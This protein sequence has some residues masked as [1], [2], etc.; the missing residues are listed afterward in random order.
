MVGEESTSNGYGAGLVPKSEVTNGFVLEVGDGNGSGSLGPWTSEGLRTY[1]RRKLAKVNS[2][3]KSVEDGRSSAEA[4]VRDVGGRNVKDNSYE[5]V[6]LSKNRCNV[7][8]ND[9]DPCLGRHMRDAVLEQM[10][11]SLRESE[12]GI[13][14]C[15]QNAIVCPPEAN[16]ATKVKDT[17]H[18]HEDKNRWFS[19]MK[20]MPDGSLNAAGGHAGVT[21]NGTLDE[22]NCRS[23]TER[24]ERALFSVIESEQFSSLCKLLVENFQGIKVDSFFDFRLINSRIKEGAYEDS[25]MLFSSDIQQVWK[26]VQKI[27]S[28][29]LSL[30]K[31]VSDITKTSC[32]EWVQSRI[33]TSMQVGGSAHST[34]EDGKHEFCGRETDA[35]LEQ[36]GACGVN[37]ACACRRCGGKADGKD[38]LVCDSCEE[39]YH[40]SCIEPA[41]KEIPAR[42]WYCADC[43]ASGIGS[44]H[45][46]CVV[47]ERLNAPK[48]RSNAVTDIVAT[49]ELEE[50]SDYIMEDGLQVLGGSRILCICK[51]CRGEIENGEKFRLCGHPYCQFKCLHVRCLTSKQLK[52]YGPLWYCPSCLCRVCL[53]DRDDD[54]IV[55]CD[56]CD[57]AYHIY[58]MEPPRASIPRGKWFCKKCAP[59][60]QRIRKAKR[61][62]ERLKRK[63]KKDEEEHTQAFENLEKQEESD[64]KDELERAGGVDMLLTA[65]KTLNYEEKLAAIKMKG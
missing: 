34:F 17:V 10:Y 48:A 32:H 2:E 20:S 24:C 13:L 60:I 49:N 14:G 38:C 36:I 15:I 64:G 40:V 62:Y 58:C 46:N 18:C 7:I 51:I 52:S 8:M 55:L 31:S 28:E 3:D 30:A 33:L 6:N 53:T 59:E 63:Q 37:K 54:K 22:A 56:G 39:M 19:Q 12:G 21:S 1:K 50:S 65:A 11:K 16:F 26:N 29:M 35:K 27:G 47:C 43:T 23:F 57:N 61:A 4:T 5:Q 44:P 9:P 41:V 45:E 25:P 42:S